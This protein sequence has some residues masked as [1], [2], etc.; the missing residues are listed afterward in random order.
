MSELWHACAAL[1]QRGDPDRFAAGMVAPVAARARLFPLWAFNLEVARAPWTTQEPMIGE[2]RLQFWRDVL[3]EIETGRQP[4]AHEVAAPLA[5]L[6]RPYP[7]LLPALDG[8]ILARRW[9]L[10]RDPFADEAG[11]QAHLDA[12]WGTLAWAGA[13][14]LRASDEGPIRRIG[15]AQG[16]AAWLEAVPELEARGCIPL[17]DGRP[18]AVAALARG[19]LGDLCDLRDCR[20]GPADVALRSGWRAE[21]VLRR[22]VRDPG[23]VARGRLRGAGARARLSLAWRCVRGRR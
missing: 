13:R 16:V 22:A 8:L 7:E 17:V 23:S 21:A 6:L 12:I 18:A 1:V 9:D 15:R 3:S 11:F 2:M 20:F 14:L 10:Y 5:E 4:R 19:A